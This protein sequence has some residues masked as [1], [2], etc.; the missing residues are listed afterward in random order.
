ML[1]ITFGAWKRSSRCYFK[2]VASRIIVLS[3][4]ALAWTPAFLLFFVGGKAFS[5]L[6]PVM[7]FC[8]LPDRSGEPGY[9]ESC[10][11]VWGICL[12][13]TYAMLGFFALWFKSMWLSI[14]FAV[15]LIASVLSV[16]V[17]GLSSINGIH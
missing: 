17:R 13:A 3:A 1:P 12:M 15:L 4:A 11:L 6:L 9:C 5:L 7:G 10:A 14:G 16:I 8:P 2:G